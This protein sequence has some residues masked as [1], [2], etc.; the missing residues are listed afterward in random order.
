MTAVELRGITKRF[1]GVVANDGVDFEAA[2][3]EVHA[4]L[5][6]N[7]AGKSTLSNILTG[8]YRPDEGEILLGGEA[9]SFS[10]PRDAL[11]AGV[12]M[13]HQHFRLVPPFTV[14][15]N[16]ILG[17][18]RGEGKKFVVHPRRIERRVAELGERYRIAVDPR[19]RIW[20][21]SLGEQQRVEILKALYR[22]ARVLI[23]DEPTAVLTPQEAESLFE[24]LR[25]M[26]EEGRTIIF[27]SHKLHEVKAVADRVTV[28]R[29]G[30]T[31]G[32][33]DCASAT[34]RSLA[35]LMVGREVSLSE[36]VERPTQ[37]G[38]PVLEVRGLR[39]AGDRGGESLRGVDLTVCAGEIVA[40]AGVAG[41]GQRELA[42]T[43]TGM[44]SPAAGEI[45]VNGK[46]LRG[47]D[48]REA[49]HAG[50]AHVPEDR[51]H[52]GVAPSLSIASNTV[53]KSYRGKHM[54]YGPMLK[55]ASIREH[56]AHLIHRYDVRGG[57]PDL[58]ARQLS[59][60]NLQKV[61]L[62]REFHGDP[63]VLVV[64]SPT[65]GLDVS[66]I[67]TVHRY[68][69]EAASSGVGVLLISEDLDEILAL[70]DRVAVMYEGAIVGARDSGEATVEEI[71]LL[72]AGGE[73]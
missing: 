47:G 35:A 60:G 14:A 68:L 59:G 55:L 19:A 10:S 16:V 53:L 8:L 33:V 11:D 1:P 2:E 62:A 18:H 70:A 25:V 57:G 58:P 44:R 49:I 27:I 13:V 28:L 67:E 6:E 71:G 31:V 72:M 63:R 66:A 26:A 32:T 38:P 43:I 29:D 22:E 45:V 12:G 41:N 64:A 73:K 46:K 34:P 21:L 36:R 24:T 9:V 50:V 5:G 40:I 65:R 17:D 61:V 52:T 56:A 7:G 4:L 48:A 20:Q 15:E 54:G 23:L 51:L 37:I 42:E 30:K 69:R 3:G 39:G